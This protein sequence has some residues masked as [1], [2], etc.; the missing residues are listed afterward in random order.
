MISSPI[1]WN[2]NIFEAGAGV[3]FMETT[4]DFKFD[5]DEQLQAILNSNPQF[6]AA[7]SDL[8]DV[9]NFNRYRAYLQNNFRLTEKFTFHPSL[10]FDYYN[11]LIK[12]TSHH[13]FLCRMLLMN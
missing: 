12:P 2:E 10:R 7:L 13:E 8:K 3:D 9:Q 1:F 4:M 6:R 5:L 11:I